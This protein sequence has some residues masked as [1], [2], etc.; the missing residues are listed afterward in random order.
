MRALVD[1]ETDV[2]IVGAG[3]VGLAAAIELGQRGVRCI[4]VERNDRVGYSPR[5]KTTNVR[6]R[7]HL[8]RWG[9]A[10]ALRRASPISPNRPSTVVFATRMNGPLIA[11][12]E[13][14]LNGSRVRNNLYS[15]EAQW[16]PQYVLEDVLRQCAQSL[17][18]VTIL[19]EIEFVS[20]TQTASGV[21]IQVRDVRR[22][23]TATMQ[24]RYLIGA[25]G[26]RSS[27][28]DAIG[29]TMIGEGA[30]SRNFSIIFRAPDLSAQQIHGPAIMY[31]MLNEEMPSLLGPMDEEGLW[32]FMIT[33]LPASVDP[34]TV[35]AGDLIRRGTG[36]RDLAIEVVGTD[37]WVAHRLVA[38]HYSRGHVFLAGDACHLHPPFGGFGMNMGIGD[39]V[40]LGWKMAA[41]F[42]GWGGDD[43]LPT[44]EIER[45]PIHERTIAEAVHNF[46]H[47]G[48]Q[49]IRPDLEAP[50]A[51]GE[52]T[53]SEVADLI[54]ATKMREFKTLGIVLGM[55]Y[56]NSPII[57]ADG[58]T[59]PPEHFM[60]YVPSAHPGCLA[61]HLWLTDGS[62]L[63]DH[64]GPGFTLLITEGDEH[65]ADRLAEAATKSNIPL[66]VLTPMN[67]RLHQRYE[68]RYA[69]IRPD[70]HVAWRGNDIPADC[71]ALL[72][73]VTGA[74]RKAGTTQALEHHRVR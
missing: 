34:A 26:A 24:S 51:V 25:D 59:P 12:F 1:M 29:V 52:A 20:L 39:A 43:L 41:H 45:R 62:S 28:R 35:D 14:A 48:T 42:A 18:D 44:Y 6:S 2:A 57:V 73:H 32:T 69:L 53:R 61:P 60:L 21:A 70:Q 72:T 17:P 19:F 66:K 58:S 8:R 13:N 74:R 36:L 40:D 22:N 3:P 50:G 71:E 38:D 46:D 15:E 63:Y 7:E 10:D 55:R 31:W 9:I 33:K 23:R 49:I 67:A 27:V 54:E 16:V 11:R 56:V 65:A 68:A 47:T 37:L 5:A 64:F 30:Y 4:V